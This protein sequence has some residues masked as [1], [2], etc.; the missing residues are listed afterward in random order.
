MDASGSSWQR[1]F[2]WYGEKKHGLKAG[3]NDLEQRLNP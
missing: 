3:V 1:V 2:W